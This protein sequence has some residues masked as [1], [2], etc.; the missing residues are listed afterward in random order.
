MSFCL[1]VVKKTSRLI[2]DVC[3]TLGM[4]QNA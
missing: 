2:S 1:F 4:D 3:R